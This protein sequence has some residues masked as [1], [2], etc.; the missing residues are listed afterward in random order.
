MKATLK[1]LLPKP[2]E[3]A[4]WEIS[5]YDNNYDWGYRVTLSDWQ[6]IGF[7]TESIGVDLYG[8]ASQPSDNQLVEVAQGILI[9]LYTPNSPPYYLVDPVGK[10]FL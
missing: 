2:F 7:W 1:S 10:Y 9:R 5:R 8:A 6:G 3:G 4:H